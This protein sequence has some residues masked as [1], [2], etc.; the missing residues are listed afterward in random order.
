MPTEKHQIFV[1]CLSGTL[2]G[3]SLDESLN[4]IN[5]Q[6]CNTLNQM[7]VLELSWTDDKEVDILVAC[8]T[9]ETQSVQLFNTET[10]KFTQTFK[11]N[12]GEGDIIGI[13]NY[14]NSILVA[15][16]SG[17]ITRLNS[18][19]EELIV[20]NSGAGLCKMRQANKL[21]ATGGL[22]NPLKLFDVERKK[23]IFIAKNVKNDFLGLKV[24]IWISDI[25]FFSGT[26][27][28]VTASKHGHVQLYDIRAQ[29]RPVIKVEMKSEALG[30]LTSHPSKMQVIVGSGK[31]RM[32]LIDLRNEGKVLN[33]YKGSAGSITGIAITKSGDKVIS[34]SLDRTLRIH[35]INTKLI[36]KKQYLSTRLTSLLTRSEFIL[37]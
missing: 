6:K 30:S 18:N 36:L 26:S 3:I 20:W 27:K 35:D 9:K 16:Q 37:L 28:I 2:K 14:Y 10:S 19:E 8:C 24:P 33:S 13:C 25:G 29:R 17:H 23:E 7:K 11:C 1:G 34:T 5:L 12:E 32:N 31:G 21:I 22:E 4:V 15:R